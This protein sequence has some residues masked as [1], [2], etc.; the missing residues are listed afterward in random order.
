MPVTTTLHVLR[1]DEVLDQ[2]RALRSR[3][4]VR[5]WAFYSSQLGGIV[6]DPALMVIPFDDHMVHRGHGVFDT[7]AMVDGR[8]TIRGASRPVHPLS[9]HLAAHAPLPAGG[10]AGDHR[11]HRGGERQA[12]R[13]HPLL[14]LGGARKPRPAA[15]GWRSSRLLRHDLRRPR[16]PR[17]LALPGAA[18]HDDHL[19]DQAAALCSHQEHQLPAQCPHPDGGARRPGSTTVSSST[20]PATWARAPT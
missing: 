5:Y 8:S 10:D 17:H 2:L 9:D 18:R 3:Q 12:R 20:T 16:L 13:L 11:A 19:P 15:R 7:A 14:D 6:T 1:S 4:P